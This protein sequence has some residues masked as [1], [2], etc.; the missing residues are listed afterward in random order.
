MPWQLLMQDFAIVTFAVEPNRLAA[1]LPHSF[2]PDVFTLDSGKEAAF[3]SAVS[4]RV[5]SL[6]CRGIRIP[7]RYVQANYRAYV[8]RHEE[9]CVWFFGSSVG[10]PI[11]AVPRMVVGAPWHFGT[12]RIAAAWDGE[13]CADYAFSNRGSWGEAEFSGSGSD[14]LR[15]RLDGFADLEETLAVLGSPRSGFS[16]R[17]DGSLLELRVEHD[18]LQP[19]LGAAR[20]ARFAVFKDLN[21][22]APQAIPHSVLLQRETTFTLLPFRFE[23]KRF[24]RH[25]LNR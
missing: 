25:G 1:L 18:V 19:Q 22:I 6:S 24:R 16:L 8:R 14:S 11:V 13:R 9:R 20:D 3:V 12:S 2:E 17:R 5:D 23:T 21:L 10:S 15:S 4:F 7:L